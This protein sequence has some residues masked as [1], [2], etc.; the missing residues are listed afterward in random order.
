MPRKRH[1]LSSTPEY[2]A[3]RNMHRRCNNP[4]DASYAAYGGRG[5]RVCERW[6]D[7]LQFVMDMGPQPEGFQLDR[8]DP[9]G[10][11]MPENCRWASVQTQANNRRRT[12]RLEFKGHLLPLT[13]VARMISIKPNT[14]WARLFQRNMPQD[15]ALLPQ[16]LRRPRSHGTRHGY[17]TG[18]R[19]PECRAAHA[20][21]HRARR[22]RRK[23]RATANRSMKREASR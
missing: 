13:E 21:H 20:A 7:L 8:I 10:D 23:T 17:D 3:W 15:R 9:N 6:R 4:A 5:I 16:S 22:A 1:N 12:I 11:Y 2:L 14:L 19:C 18:C